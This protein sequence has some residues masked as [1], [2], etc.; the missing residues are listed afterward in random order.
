MASPSNSPP[1][2]FKRDLAAGK[3][4]IGCWCSLANPNTA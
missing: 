2:A 1:I 4:L 3:R